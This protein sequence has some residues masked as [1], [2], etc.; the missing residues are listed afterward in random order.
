VAASPQKLAV[1]TVSRR[2]TA[3][4]WET[5]DADFGR[6]I[7]VMLFLAGFAPTS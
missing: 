7:L 1:V 6:A 4:Q 2:G 5:M 3:G